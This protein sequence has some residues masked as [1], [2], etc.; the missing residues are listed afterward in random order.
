MRSQFLHRHPL[1]KVGMFAQETL[2]PAGCIQQM[3]GN[4]VRHHFRHQVH[5]FVFKIVFR[6]GM[7]VQKLYPQFHRQLR[8][9]GLDDRTDGIG[10]RCAQAPGGITGIHVVFLGKAQ[11]HFFAFLIRDH[12]LQDA[13]KDEIL[14]HVVIAL[15][16]Q[17]IAFFVFGDDEVF[18]KLRECAW[19]QGAQHDVL[20][21]LGT[22]R[23]SLR[24]CSE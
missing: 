18:F 4:G 7:L 15:S 2:H 23:V 8:H 21:Q 9:A 24:V 10:R 22:N 14:G 16:Q 19:F 1:V 12:A 13:F 20:R 6:R 5:D 17:Q 3:Q 11:D